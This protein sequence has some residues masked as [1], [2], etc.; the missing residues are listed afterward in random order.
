MKMLGIVKDELTTSAGF[1]LEFRMKPVPSL[2]LLNHDPIPID[3]HVIY[4]AEL[5]PELADK[6]DVDGFL[7]LEDFKGRISY[8]ALEHCGG[9]RLA[10]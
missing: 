5:I 4:K 2:R 10:C 1:V 3:D 7:S 9:L 6:T 8:K